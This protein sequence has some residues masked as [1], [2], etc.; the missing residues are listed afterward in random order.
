[1]LLECLIGVGTLSSGM[2]MQ[3]KQY[4][5]ELLESVLILK[6]SQSFAPLPESMSSQ[7]LLHK[8]LS[9][10]ILM[11]AVLANCLCYCLIDAIS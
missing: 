8:G 2:I 9:I 7:F 11:A 10:L 3:T 5:I 6:E 1:M 4:Q